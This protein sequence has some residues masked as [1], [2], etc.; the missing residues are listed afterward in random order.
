MVEKSS[1]QGGPEVALK[2]LCLPN[3]ESREESQ[4]STRFVVQHPDTQVTRNVSLNTALLK[5]GTLVILDA[6]LEDAAT[7][8]LF[9]GLKT[10]KAR[11]SSEIIIT[12]QCCS[13]RTAGA[14]EQKLLL[15]LYGSISSR[16]QD[17][18]PASG[19]HLARRGMQGHPYSPRPRLPQS[20]ASSSG[21]ERVGKLES[22]PRI[23]L[24][25]HCHICEFR[26]RCHDKAVDEDNLSL[27]R[28]MGERRYGS[29]IARG[30]SQQPSFPV[31]FDLGREARG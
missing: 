1:G 10:R 29:T 23:I 9:D 7:S 18:T 22:P 20:G 28:G 6:I 24:N 4:P 26:K 31:P 13:T 14:K 16:L 3:R 15:E 27:L 17:K 30:S 19:N 8:L 12:S 25:D 2:P 21:T 11:P 5:R